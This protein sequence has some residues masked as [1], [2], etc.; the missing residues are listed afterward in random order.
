MFNLSGNVFA[1]S[2]WTRIKTW[3]TFAVSHTGIAELLMPISSHLK[4]LIQKFNAT[5]FKDKD[6]ANKFWTWL[7]IYISI[8]VLFVGN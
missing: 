6:P 4:S 5:W 8:V 7:I 1:M 2:N 3:I